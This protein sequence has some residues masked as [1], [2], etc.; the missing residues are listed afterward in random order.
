MP[1]P[2]TPFDPSTSTPF[3]PL[4]PF[5]WLRAQ[6]RLRL[7]QGS[8]QASTRS[9]LRAQGSGLRAQGSGLRAQDRPLPKGERGAIYVINHLGLL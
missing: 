8:G 4:R 5:D 9:G 7:A 1:S 6:D 2:P 3:D